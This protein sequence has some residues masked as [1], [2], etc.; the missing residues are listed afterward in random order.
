MFRFTIERL[1]GA[2]RPS[3]SLSA[4]ESGLDVVM[5]SLPTPWTPPLTVLQYVR[6]VLSVT[7]FDVVY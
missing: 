2:H 7:V 3:Q 5:I 6:L 4:Q 1:Q